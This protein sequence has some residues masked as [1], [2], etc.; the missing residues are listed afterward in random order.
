LLLEKLGYE[1]IIP[2]HEES[3]RTWLSKG[4]LR[5]AQKIINRNITALSPL[6]SEATP[7]IGIEP[8][9]IL[10]FRMNIPIL[11]R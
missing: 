6:I 5:D 9:A 10:T 11:L 1:V 7:L 4:L 3:G 8:S 2:K